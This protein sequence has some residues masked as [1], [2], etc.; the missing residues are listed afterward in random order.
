[1]YTHNNVIF[2]VLVEF[3][4]IYHLTWYKS[5]ESLK[6]L[7]QVS[8]LAK[9]HDSDDLYVN[10]DT[11]VLQVFEESNSMIKLNLSVPHKAKV[12]LFSEHDVKQNKYLLQVILNRSAVGAL[13]WMYKCNAI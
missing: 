11:V 2:K 8:P 9:M 7:L 5:V 12:L 10:L 4:M 3:E 6:D 1:M 13:I